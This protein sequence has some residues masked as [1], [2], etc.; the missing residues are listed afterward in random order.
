MADLHVVRIVHDIL[1]HILEHC[2]AGEHRVYFGAHVLRLKWKEI[3][4]FL[5]LYHLVGIGKSIRWENAPRNKSIV[6]IENLSL[7]LEWLNAIKYQIM[8][9]F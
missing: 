1:D 8:K 2:V 5:K 7:E 3:D 4:V 9:Y 6:V